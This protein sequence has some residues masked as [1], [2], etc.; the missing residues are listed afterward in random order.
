MGIGVW[1]PGKQRS[2][3][4]EQLE[5]LLDKAR[6][7]D[8]NQLIS[9]CD[10]EFVEANAWVMKLEEGAWSDSDALPDDDLVALIRFFTLAEMQLAGWEAG[11]QNPVIYLVRILKSRGEFS[12]DLRKWIRSNTD[13]RYLPYG[14]AL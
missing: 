7:I 11:K 3:S 13:N 5:T 4:G 1:Q 14:A 8:P 10:R 6:R 12:A 2:V 9:T